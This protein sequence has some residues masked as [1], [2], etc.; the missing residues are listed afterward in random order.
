[1]TLTVTRLQYLASRLAKFDD[2]ECKQ[3]F[4]LV[5][6]ALENP[7]QI[8]R[9]TTAECDL[10]EQV[11]LH[12][13]CALD[14]GNYTDAEEFILDSLESEMAG[15]VHG[16]RL[17]LKSV[18]IV[19]ITSETNSTLWK[20]LKKVIFFVLA[21]I[22]LP[23]CLDI[24]YPLEWVYGDP[25]SRQQFYS[26]LFPGHAH[27]VALISGTAFVLFG[28]LCFSPWFKKYGRLSTT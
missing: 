11:W 18:S 15:R 3:A 14:H 2:D 6:K 20:T 7:E 5:S 4:I 24:Y 19:P 25:V 27:A 8:E 26:L 28:L 1:M 23:A 13:S 9:S 10:Y 16:L 22:F 17:L 12:M 21:A